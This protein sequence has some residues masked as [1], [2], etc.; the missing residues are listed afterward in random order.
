MS[1]SALMSLG[2]RAM[3]A[4]YA[5]LQTTSQNIANANVE[6]YSRQQVE[7][8]TAMGQYTGAGFFGKGVDV[9][10]VSRSY[11]QFLTKEAASTVS[12]RRGST[13][14]SSWRTCSPPAPTASVTRP[15]SSSTR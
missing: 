5:Q 11:D 3:F 2:T 12:T 10:T 15:T 9:A 7:L 6:G 4:S 8:K 14:S 13:S 1:T